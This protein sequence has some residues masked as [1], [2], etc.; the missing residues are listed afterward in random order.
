MEKEVFLE[1]KKLKLTPE[2]EKIH[3]LGKRLKDAELESYY[4]KKHI[5]F[6]FLYKYDWF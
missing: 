1:K 3:E 2:Q 6:V 4:I 5:F